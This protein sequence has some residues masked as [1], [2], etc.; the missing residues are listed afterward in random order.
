MNNRAIDI[1][2]KISVITSSLVILGAGVL[3][4]TALYDLF[5][6]LGLFSPWLAFLFP[7]LFDLAEVTA[8]VSVLN[9][10]L[11]GETDRFAWRLVIGFTVAGVV[12]NIAHAGH[13]WYIGKID[14]VQL[15]LAVV[16]TSLFPLSIALVTH[17]LKKTIERQIGRLMTIETI[18][19]LTDRREQLSAAVS[20]LDQQRD[21]L[22]DQVE[23]ERERLADILSDQRDAKRATNRAN[24][25]EMNAAKATKIEERREQ[26]FALVTQGWSNSDIA[27][28]LDVSAATVRRDI[29]ALNGRV[30][31]S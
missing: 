25:E 14:P 18:A 23:R 16:F 28:E 6:Q 7:L 30:G 3:S 21:T 15:G 5:N 8:A 10:K 27:D 31:V 11:Q 20:D 1:T 12:A 22:A 24:V 29:K 9:A 2:T 26:V 4:F 19:D 17:L 13:A